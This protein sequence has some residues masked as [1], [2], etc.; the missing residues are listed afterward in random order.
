MKI[1]I[2]LFFIYLLI[3]SK[4]QI[5]APMSKKTFEFDVEDICFYQERG[6]DYKYVEPCEK[7]YSCEDLTQSLIYPQLKICQEY[8]EAGIAF[9]SDCNEE[10]G[11]ENDLTCVENICTVAENG[12]AQNIKGNYYCSDKLIPILDSSN[13]ICKKI[14]DYQSVKG[15]CYY[16]DSQTLTVTEAWPDYN[17]VCGNIEIDEQANGYRKLKVSAD[18]IGSVKDGNLVENE[19]ACKSG[20]ALNFYAD[21]SIGD[22]TTTPT[23]IPIYKK[24]VQFEGYEIKGSYCNI[25]YT[26]DKK[27]YN[28]DANKV[29]NYLI[30]DKLDFCNNFKFIRTKLELFKQYVDKTNELVDECTKKK[31]YDEPYTCKNDE[32]RKLY[33]FY[34]N[35]QEYLLYK[36]EEEI[37]EFL[38]QKQYY[39]YGVSYS[40]TDNSQFMCSNL[41]SLLLIIGFFCL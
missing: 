28:Y 10:E 21:G 18:S 8:S 17:K 31:Y 1:L 24:C 39:D 36:N 3:P 14:D 26:L 41:I 29:S 13:Y 32:L 20:F 34:S 15:L 9:G 23:T 2:L 40:K 5:Y 25:K 11:C 30:K 27:R 19:F 22:P 16:Y 4:S 7:G 35:P 12:Q 38:L 6:S 33:Y 37:T